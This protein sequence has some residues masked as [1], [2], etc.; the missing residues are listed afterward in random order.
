M[1]K[2]EKLQRLEQ[3]FGAAQTAVA[4]ID[5]LVSELGINNIDVEPAGA[6]TVKEANL[7]STE[8]EHLELFSVQRLLTD[9]EM[10]RSNIIR[11]INTGQRILEST[12][13]LDL[14]DLKASQLDALTNLQRTIA[15]NTKMLLEIYKD[16]AAI[17]KARGAGKAKPVDV[18][19][20]NVMTGPVT[21][22]NIVFQ[23]S[24]AELMKLIHNGGKVIEGETV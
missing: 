8:T 21:Q 20:G 10:V 9:F 4:Q 12:Q 11:L 15:E 22:N 24:T 16:M 18:P 17:E 7:P 14:G 3:K 6:L 23:G 1:N 5:D 19:A 2:S 13:V